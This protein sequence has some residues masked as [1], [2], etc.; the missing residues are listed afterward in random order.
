MSPAGE[1]RT[2]TKI[3]T[4]CKLPA[5]SETSAKVPQS[6][7]LR[8]GATEESHKCSRVR[9]RTDTPQDDAR[10]SFSSGASYAPLNHSIN[11]QCRPASP[12]GDWIA[13]G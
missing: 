10:K 8:D 6:V 12:G 7:I 9:L 2:V 3:P 4:S 13:P 5:L 11:G 1:A